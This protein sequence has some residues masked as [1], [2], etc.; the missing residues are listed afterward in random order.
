MSKIEITEQTK[1][2]IA[3]AFW[4]L[5]TAKKIEK[6]TVREIAEKAGYNRSTFYTYFKD[7]YD[8]LDYV[9]ESLLKPFLMKNADLPEREIL[10]RP[11]IGELIDTIV[12][13]YEKYGKYLSVLLSENGDPKF[14]IKIKQRII[15]EI[16][17]SLKIKNINVTA[18]TEYV[19]E[20]NFSA[21]FNIFTYWHKR[22]KDIPL[23][24]VLK[25][26]HTMSSSLSGLLTE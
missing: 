25:I 19:L 17:A 2:N 23:E 21:L 5:Y 10:H 4:K 24:D 26:H 8:L 3:D 12:K 6:I 14:I 1:Q 15:P 11:D 18:K 22:N 16:I 20:Y 13:Y 9:E 7:V